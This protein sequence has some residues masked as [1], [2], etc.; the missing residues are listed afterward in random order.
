MSMIMRVTYILVQACI[1]FM[2]VRPGIGACLLS[3]DRGKLNKQKHTSLSW[4]LSRVIGSF[5]H[6][7]ILDFEISQPTID[8][9]SFSP[10]ASAFYLE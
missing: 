6:S 4:E 8:L 5:S 1:I 10:S 9:L 7:S 3:L 2:N